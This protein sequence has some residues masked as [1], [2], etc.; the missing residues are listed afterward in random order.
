MAHIQR[1]ALLPF[2]VEQMFQL[3]NNVGEYPLYLDGCS[4]TVIH[5]ENASEMKATL[6]LEKHGIKLEFTTVNTIDAPKS[7]VLLLEDGPF[8]EFEGRWFFQYLADDACKVMLDLRFQLTGKL[9]SVAAGKLLNS[10]G[11]NMVDAM[12]KRAKQIYG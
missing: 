10:V 11:N 6:V 1:H 2:S 7:I 9:T 4:D 5:A 12:V 3:V 8:N